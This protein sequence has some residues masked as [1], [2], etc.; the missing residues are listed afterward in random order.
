MQY[1][2]RKPVKDEKKAA[3]GEMYRIA[4]ENANNGEHIINFAS[5]HPDTEILRG[6]LI[7]KYVID[8]VNDNQSSF[9]QYGAHIRSEERI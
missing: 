3:M 2:F 9:F 4:K 5:G 1:Q 7:T 6:E 8:A